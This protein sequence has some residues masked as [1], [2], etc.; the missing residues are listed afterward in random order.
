MTGL[1]IAAVSV[2]ISIGTPSF[3]QTVATTAEAAGEVL[4]MEEAAKKLIKKAHQAYDQ[5]KKITTS[6]TIEC[7]NKKSVEKCKDKLF[8]VMAE[9]ELGE[10][11]ND[12]N[13][14]F[15][16][17][18]RTGITW[19]EGAGKLL[20]VYK[21]GKLNVK[22]IY[23]GKNKDWRFHHEEIIYG[24]KNIK[25]LREV[26][27]GMSEKDKSW[28]IAVWLMVDHK[29][30]YYGD[31]RKVATNEKDVAKNRACGFCGDLA[32]L[33]CK[34]ARKLGIKTGQVSSNDHAINC[35]KIDGE[36]YYLEMQ[37]VD[38]DH[39]DWVWANSLDYND[40]NVDADFKLIK[41][42]PD[43]TGRWLKV[44]QSDAKAMEDGTITAYAWEMSEAEYC[45]L[46][47]KEAKKKLPEEGF[48]KPS[49]WK[50]YW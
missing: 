14:D 17:S 29:T 9:E 25:E 1:A 15:Q 12:A 5:K 4:S 45:L 39:D 21:N 49:K 23:K 28:R 16:L 41:F 44:P 7:P 43:P 34:Y 6:V 36:V 27:E 30:Y 13:L 24:L 47:E 26:T 35:V 2:M 11:K 18:S 40:E 20:P 22:I 33:Y 38:V 42:V 19:T 31:M 48:G 50:Y 32:S 46:T 37:G 8:K 3:N 10:F